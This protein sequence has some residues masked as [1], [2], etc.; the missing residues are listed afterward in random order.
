LSSSG[1]RENRSGSRDLSPCQKKKKKKKKKGNAVGLA[2]AIYDYPCPG[3]LE[4]GEGGA[5][6]Y[7]SLP[8]LFL[9]EEE[10]EKKKASNI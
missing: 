8:F 1:K 9:Y 4:G 3:T 5:K 6:I 7:T 2:Y 10:R